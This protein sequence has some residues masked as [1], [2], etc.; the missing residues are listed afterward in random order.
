MCAFQ[1][2]FPSNPPMYLPRRVV[3]VEEGETKGSGMNLGRSHSFL[4]VFQCI[5]ITDVRTWPEVAESVLET[6]SI[7]W[8]ND[9]FLQ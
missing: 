5:I 8:T 2:L 1:A 9:E 4:D 3:S 7:S 6:D